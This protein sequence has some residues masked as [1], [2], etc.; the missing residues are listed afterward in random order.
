MNIYRVARIN[1]FEQSL[2]TW[3]FAP[4][5]RVREKRLL[6]ARERHGLG[7]DIESTTKA[8][9]HGFLMISL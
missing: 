6:L 9:Y 3:A 4:K 7:A 5:A 1:T 8:S 2:R